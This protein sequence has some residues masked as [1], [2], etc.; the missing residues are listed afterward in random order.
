[1]EESSRQLNLKREREGTVKVTFRLTKYEYDNIKKLAN[2]LYNEKAL[3]RATVSSYSRAA[4][5]KSY[6]DMNGP[7]TQEAE[8]KK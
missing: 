6:D 5:I 4:V 7:I 3:P 1:M 2:Y 8:E